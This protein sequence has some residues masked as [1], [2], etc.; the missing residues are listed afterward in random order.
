MIHARWRCKSAC[1]PHCCAQLRNKDHDDARCGGAPLQG[2][3]QGKVTL[4]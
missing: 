1:M 4:G 3:E 2:L